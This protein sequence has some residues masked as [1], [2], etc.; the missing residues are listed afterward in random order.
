MEKI[1][2]S[3][4]F[5]VFVPAVS[6]AE[7]LQR[8][9]YDQ[10][11]KLITENYFPVRKKTERTMSMYFAQI[12]PAFDKRL[13]TKELNADLSNDGL[14]FAWNEEFFSIAADFPKKQEEFPIVSLSDSIKGVSGPDSHLVST[15]NNNKRILWLTNVPNWNYVYRFPVIQIR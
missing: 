9:E 5:N 3:E 13:T 6:F 1:I 8:G 15:F 4:P 14:C 7:H 10:I 11:N 2:Y 12:N